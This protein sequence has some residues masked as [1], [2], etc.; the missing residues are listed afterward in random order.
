MSS[1]SI[2]KFDDAEIFA[3][4]KR[5]SGRRIESRRRRD[6]ISQARLAASIGRSERWVRDME[7][8]IATSTIEDHVR[9][10]HWL[11]MSTAHIFI[12]LLCMEHGIPLPMKLLELET[13]W[14]VEESFIEALVR[15]QAKMDRRNP[16]R[17]TR[18][19]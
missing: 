14:D 9:C 10:A 6:R 13:L 15:E 12:P 1:Q 16:V 2:P 17:S 7:A 5:L 4:V 19:P 3:L 18:K 11:G 8:G